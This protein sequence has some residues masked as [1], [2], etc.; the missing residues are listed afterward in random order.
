MHALAHNRHTVTGVSP[1]ALAA[2]LTPGM[3]LAQARSLVPDLLTAEEDA[4]AQRIA[5]TDLCS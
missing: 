5:L 4:D 3:P 1:A 2:G